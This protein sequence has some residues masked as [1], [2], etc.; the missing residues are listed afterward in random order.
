MCVSVVF[1]SLL[2]SLTNSC[3]PTNTISVVRFF[4][5]TAHSCQLNSHY[6]SRNYFQP[7][8]FDFWCFWHVHEAR[9]FVLGLMRERTKE[10]SC[11]HQLDS[12]RTSCGKGYQDT[13]NKKLTANIKHQM[14]WCVCA[15]KC[16]RFRTK[17]WSA[18]VSTKFSASTIDE[19]G[20]VAHE[21]ALYMCACVC[22]WERDK[23][24]GICPGRCLSTCVRVWMR[25]RG[26]AN[27][28]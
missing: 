1:I 4:C 27:V 3:R 26:R 8:K 15:S 13:E 10:K 2:F 19:I 6:R 17:K 22:E 14:E 16:A 23:G 20:N 18:K 24:I 25:K 9:M 5:K 7:I 11:L 21:N 28:Y 12:F